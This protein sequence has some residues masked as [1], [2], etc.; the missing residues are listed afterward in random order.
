[1]MMSCMDVLQMILERKVMSMWFYVSSDQTEIQ[2]EEVIRLLRQSYWAAERSEQSIRKSIQHSLCFGAYLADTKQQIAFGRV[3]TDY[4]VNYYLC[5]VIVDTAYRGRG[6]GRALVEGI[7]FDAR[8][9]NLKGILSSRDARGLYEK[10]D[11][12]VENDR[13]MIRW[14]E[15]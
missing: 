6:V 1:M 3:L 8:L 14:P 15:N 13:F 12:H 7:F 4:A 10:Y 5:D 11:F 9:K 2:A